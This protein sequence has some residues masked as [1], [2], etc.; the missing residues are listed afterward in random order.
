MTYDELT[1]HLKKKHKADSSK[2]DQLIDQLIESGKIIVEM[3]DKEPELSQTRK[4]RTGNLIFAL[5]GK[6]YRINYGKWQII[7]VKIFDFE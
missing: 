1:D 7:E 3:V 4:K 5:R 2:I 6:S